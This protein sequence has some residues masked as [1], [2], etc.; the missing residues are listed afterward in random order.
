V[1]AI[2]GTIAKAAGK[3][4]RWLAAFFNGGDDTSSSKRALTIG[5]GATLCYSVIRLTN[6]IARAIEA[7]TPVSETAAWALGTLSVPV[8]A[9]AGVIYVL[10][11]MNKEQP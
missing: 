6:A 8:A 4:V 5:A 9:M 10:Q 2:W 3:F 7:G 1:S 11:R